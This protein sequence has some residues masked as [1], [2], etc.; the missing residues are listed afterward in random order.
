[1]TP[2][3]DYVIVGAG[4]AGCVLANRL[5]ED[6]TISVLL[7]EAGGS[8]SSLWISMPAAFA[9]AMFMPRFI[10]SYLSEPEPGLDN[11]HI[12]SPRG[13]LLGGSS[14]INGM[15]YVRGNALDYETWV[16][17]GAAGWSYREVLPYFRRSEAF[18]G[19]ADDYRGGE[20][21][22][23]TRQASL[24]CVLNRIFIEAAG[25]AGYAHNPDCNGFRQEGFGAMSMSIGGGRRS[26]TARAYLHPVR[27]R[28]NLRV[29]TDAAVT[30][31]GWSGNRIDGVAYQRGGARREATARREVIL[32]AGT[33]NSPQLLMLAG[34]GPG[35]Q[36]QAHGI[37]VKNDLPGVGNHLVDHCGT[38]VRMQCTQPVSMQPALGKLRRLGVGLRW[39]ISKTGP[40]AS[41]QFEAS[42]FLRS[43]AHVRYPDLQLDF[44][45]YA[46]YPGAKTLSVDHGFQVH[47][48]PLRAHSRGHVRL[49]S[50]H[51][52][53]APLITYN[54]LDDERDRTDM[55]RAIQLAREIFAQPAFDPYRGH[56]LT[57]GGDCESDEAIDAYVRATAKTVYHPTS[58]C[59]MGVDANS[60]VDPQCRVHGVEGLRVVDASV[61][62]MV[63]SGNTNAP[64]IMIAEKVSDLI[65]GMDPMAPTEV[66]YFVAD[67]WRTQQRPREPLR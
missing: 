39:L 38:F 19:G 42:G 48:G 21:P 46:V 66:D 31:L 33:I 3:F 61:M 14:S 9:D 60:V 63:T 12:E 36:L 55:R 6:P 29:E 37:E 41:N 26:S 54:Y 44:M 2:E 27:H 52:S 15:V 1:M 16:D 53:A 11:R 24:Q 45:P 13:K 49:A 40:A 59:R 10:W 8:D 58:T 20:G 34:I 28:A 64:T 47:C 5:S 56:E 4:S 23:R 7:L 30:G 50:K 65:R 62:P 32:S 35:A 25:Q 18:A 57:P 17:M 22:M 51:P 43:R 67:D